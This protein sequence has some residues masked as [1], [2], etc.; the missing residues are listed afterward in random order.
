MPAFL[1]ALLQ[2]ALCRMTAAVVAAVLVLSPMPG[3]A[4]AATLTLEDGP[5]RVA[6]AVEVN[7]QLAHMLLRLS[8]VPLFQPLAHRQVVP[9]PP[10]WRDTLVEHLV[11]KL[12]PEA[13][14]GGNRAVGPVLDTLGADEDAP[15]RQGR[16]TGLQILLRPSRGCRH[17]G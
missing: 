15:S 5:N 13:E 3:G 11:V 12:V 7:R 4:P 14:P 17:Q 9:G 2:L 10:P 1:H 6:A 16:A 8:A